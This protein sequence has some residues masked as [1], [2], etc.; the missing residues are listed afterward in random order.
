MHG[1]AHPDRVADLLDVRVRRSGATAVVELTGEIDMVTAPQLAEVL[2]H[3]LEQR[4]SPVEVDLAGVRFLAAAG[5]AALVEAHHRYQ[6][7]AARLV[8]VRPTPVCARLLAITRLDAT[9]IIG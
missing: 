2:R 7:D 4:C 5:L 8:L 9:L 3:L 1:P 6:D